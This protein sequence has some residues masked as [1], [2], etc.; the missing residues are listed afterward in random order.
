MAN[1]RHAVPLKFHLETLRRYL[2]VLAIALWLGGFTFYSVVVI[3][4]AHHVL[5]SMLETGLITQK[6]SGWLN[7]IGV[8]TLVILLWNVVASWRSQNRLLRNLLA[9]MWVVMA[10]VE[11][12]LFV[13]HPVLDKQINLETRHLVDRQQFR[14]THTF[15]V[16]LST[17]QWVAGLIY[18]FVALH[19]WRKADSAQ[20]TSFSHA[21]TPQSARATSPRVP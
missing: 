13:L 10:A 20:A 1:I 2:V 5:D 4:T 12:W 3:H 21:A 14:R 15:Y 8:G 17:V 7:W 16:T 6:V 11:V 19:L 9:V 18:T